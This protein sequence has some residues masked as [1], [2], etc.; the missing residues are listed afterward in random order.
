[1]GLNLLLVDES[2]EEFKNFVGILMEFLEILGKTQIVQVD[3]LR[4]K[5][6]DPLPY[7]ASLF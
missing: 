6:V 1:M 4:I 3:V 7:F 2:R 5:S